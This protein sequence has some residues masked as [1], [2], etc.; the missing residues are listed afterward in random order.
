MGGAA[1]LA[2]G[3]VVILLKLLV[4]ICLPVRLS[5]IV[6]NLWAF[7]L[8]AT[9]AAT[10]DDM[11]QN[12]QI[13]F[14][15]PLGLLLS[16]IGVAALSA[17]I[18]ESLPLALLGELGTATLNLS[19]TLSQP[20]AFALAALTAIRVTD[21]L[22]MSTAPKILQIF[23]DQPQL[24]PKGLF[25]LPEPPLLH[26][27]EMHE[28][29]KRLKQLHRMDRSREESAE[30]MPPV[31]DNREEP[32]E[33]ARDASAFKTR[34]DASIRAAELSA[35]S[36]DGSQC[37]SRINE[38][39]IP[40]VV[41]FDTTEIHLKDD[42]ITAIEST[43]LADILEISYVS[44]STPG[45]ENPNYWSV[46]LQRE[47]VIYLVLLSARFV[48]R[49]VHQAFA[50]ALAARP[51]V[52]RDSVVPILVEDPKRVSS[53][54]SA[55][56]QGVPSGGVP[57]VDWPI[58]R[59]AWVNVVLS[60]RP[61]CVSQ[62]ASRL[63]KFWRKERWTRLNA[64][65][66]RP[67]GDV[68]VSA[69]EAAQGYNRVRELIDRLEKEPIHILSLK[70][71]YRSFTTDFHAIGFG[72]VS[73][74]AF[75]AANF[76]GLLASEAEGEDSKLLTILLLSSG[77]LILWTAI[78]V[79]REGTRLS[80]CAMETPREKLA[81]SGI[82]HFPSSYLV[83]SLGWARRRLMNI[84]VRMTIPALSVWALSYIFARC[85][86]CVGTLQEAFNPW[87][88]GAAG[89]V[90]YFL[91][92]RKLP[93]VL[94]STPVPTH[95][96]GSVNWRG[97]AVELENTRRNWAQR[98]ADGSVGTRPEYRGSVILR[99]RESVRVSF[100]QLVRATIECTLWF[101]IVV[102]ACTIACVRTG[103]SRGVFDFVVFFSISLLRALSAKWFQLLA[104]SLKL[105]GTLRRRMLRYL[106]L[107]GPAND[108][109][110]RLYLFFELIAMLY[111]H[112]W[113]SHEF[114]ASLVFFV[115][116]WFYTILSRWRQLVLGT[117]RRTKDVY[118]SPNQIRPET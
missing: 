66:P 15:I 50:A 113:S 96:E 81:L 79:W 95:E 28:Q 35:D 105:N 58:K 74:S 82:S 69:A 14:R 99:Y 31:A 37:P 65:R 73:S 77:L 111:G 48:G 44:E 34:P 46:D 41:L 86:G 104:G 40:A 6:A 21:R 110:L 101:L 93:T 89:G 30:E 36:R 49:G 19:P 60:I 47:E 67:T 68:E 39:K 11:L 114:G 80:R 56:Y 85:A 5:G 27:V 63:A 4:P 17:F 71:P 51:P 91:S 23:R 75:A 29:I 8:F 32:A 102:P 12:R 18:W 84:A 115:A 100:M 59:N 55:E 108:N 103:A 22:A 16:D 88:W 76:A 72:F 45:A 38:A 3:L 70:F 7:G 13:L 1:A 53:S 78:A 10:I 33:S 98:S 90:A 62:F 24:I 106:L 9:T 117:F 83:Q 26:L 61:F 107:S 64:A 2:T 43:G 25:G 109:G 94:W 92:C 112:R 42:L 118:E 116:F 52:Y 54:I 57:V 97:V 87:L 20:L